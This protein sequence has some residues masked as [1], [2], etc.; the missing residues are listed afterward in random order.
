[1]QVRK[2]YRLYSDDNNLLLKEKY[3]SL[4]KNPYPYNADSNFVYR[5]FTYR[6]TLLLS[7]Y[8]STE[9]KSGVLDKCYVTEK[10]ET[11]KYSVS[12]SLLEVQHITDGE[13]QMKESFKYDDSGFL[14]KSISEESSFG[15]SSQVIYNRRGDIVKYETYIKGKLKSRINIDY[16]YN[17]K[18]EWVRC[19]HS[20]LKGKPQ[21]LVNREIFY[22]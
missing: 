17:E 21:F 13:L 22:Y 15:N 18:G 16:I 7:A 10:A 4:R 11:Y 6:D 14:E 1:M 2:S 20:N 5:E 9:H 3:L 8:E 12:G 19:I